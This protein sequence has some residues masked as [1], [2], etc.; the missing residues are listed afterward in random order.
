MWRV[1]MVVVCAAVMMG[2]GKDEPGKGVSIFDGKTLA[3]WQ[4]DSKFWRVEEGQIV[5]GT[6]GVNQPHNDFLATE[7]SY[8]NFD[9]HLKI[10]LTGTVGFVNS[11]IQFR[12]V[13]VPNNFEMSGY[14]AD[15]GEGYWGSLYDETRRD[16]MLMP[17]MD[18][19]AMTKAFKEQ[20][21]N[22]YRVRAEG[23]HI[24]TWL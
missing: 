11:G 6:A 4:G 3:G 13:R 10:K 5:G 23:A 14:Q 18:A 7:K 9:L 17:P 8:S 1:A 12:S 16:K 15:A 24:E 2:A 19:A 21:W 22:D 20:D